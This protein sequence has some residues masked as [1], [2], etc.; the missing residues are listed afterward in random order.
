MEY[1][2][3][4]GLFEDWRIDSILIKAKDIKD[5]KKRFRDLYSN[6]RSVSGVK[7]ECVGALK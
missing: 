7:A 2:I 5:A 1:Y 4:T 3:V 6:K